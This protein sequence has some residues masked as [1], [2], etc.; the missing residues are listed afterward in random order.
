MPW[1]RSA[2]VTA[3]RLRVRSVIMTSLT[4]LLGLLHML[5]ATGAGSEIQRPLVAVVFGGLASALL[6]TL[7][8]LPVLYALVNG[9]RAEG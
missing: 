3:C 4:T 1:S 9:M 7:V 6:L 8:V 5:Y 2:V